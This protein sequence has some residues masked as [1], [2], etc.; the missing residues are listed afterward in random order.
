MTFLLHHQC[1]MYQPEEIIF[2]SL[3][4]NLAM[5]HCVSYIYFSSLVLTN[6]LRMIISI[7]SPKDN[8]TSLALRLTNFFIIKYSTNYFQNE[9]FCLCVSENSESSHDVFK[10]LVL[11]NIREARNSLCFCIFA[12]KKW[13]ST[14]NS[15]WSILIWSNRSSYLFHDN[16]QKKK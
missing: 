14:I 10:F 8:W 11:C 1:F 13:Q 9:S 6:W 4:T 12:L 15:C 16:G 7:L 2:W 3:E 5:L